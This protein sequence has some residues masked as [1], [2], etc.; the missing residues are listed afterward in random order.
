MVSLVV[1]GRLLRIHVYSLELGHLCGCCVPAGGIYVCAHAFK[2]FYIKLV[3]I[4]MCTCVAVTMLTVIVA[5][6]D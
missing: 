1:L 4:C 5:S 6:I 3:Y 2:I